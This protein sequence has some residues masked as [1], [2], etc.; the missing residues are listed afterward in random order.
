M[1]NIRVLH[2]HHALYLPIVYVREL[3]KRGVD[4]HSVYFNNANMH[5]LTGVPDYNFGFL[6]PRIPLN[7][8]KFILFF[9]KR[10]STFD[11][12]HFHSQPGFVP[13]NIIGKLNNILG[14]PLLRY[15]RSKGLRIVYSRWGCHDGRLP[16]TFAHEN[17]GKICKNC[18]TG[19]FGSSCSDK[20]TRAICESQACF[21]DSIINHE[22]DFKDYNSKV[23]YQPSIVD[24]VNFSPEIKIPQ[25]HSI[26][27]KPGY[28]YVYH[29]VG[30]GPMRGN[31]RGT[32]IINNTINELKRDG[33]KLEI[34]ST[35]GRVPY[36]DIGFYQRQA[37]LAIDN[38][39]YNWYGNMARECMAQ[40]IPVAT[41]I[42]SHYLKRHGLLY[43]AN[44]PLI[45][46]EEYNLRET[47]EY[48]YKHR[49]EL[50]EVGKKQREYIMNIHA[51][52]KVM[53]RL[54]NLYEGRFNYA[55]PGLA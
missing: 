28:M 51:T 42:D 6:S 47:I 48:F 12:V 34:I 17:E 5:W 1:S 46:I 2:V 44:P 13:N 4:A 24:F 45:K 52:D 3:R 18:K 54:L 27:K 10:V 32:Y 35:N 8:A 23:L 9:I 15:L 16:S 40:G 43:S 50:S 49:T 25:Q 36:K 20:N 14:M 37:D 11:I 22:P 55:N 39:Y 7:I 53:E 21:G 30:Q 33:Y 31:E 19:I 29:S 38:L 26:I 41:R